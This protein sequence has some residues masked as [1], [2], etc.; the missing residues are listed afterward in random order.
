MAEGVEKLAEKAIGVGLNRREIVQ[1]STGDGV[2][3]PA[4]GTV[5]KDAPHAVKGGGQRGPARPGD[6]TAVEEN[7]GGPR[8][9]TP[10]P[11]PA[12]RSRA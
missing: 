7:E 10:A 4:S 2:G 8:R 5:D 1:R 9:P 11:E 6:G 3:Q 12:L